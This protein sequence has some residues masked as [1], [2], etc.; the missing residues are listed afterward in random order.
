MKKMVALLLSLLVLCAS[1]A[2]LAEG[3]FYE[4]PIQF[5]EF[6]F[7]DT[8]QNVRN[9]QFIRTIDFKRSA[10]SPRFLAEASNY[11][12][13]WSGERSDSA[14]CF[15]ANLE[16]MREV[17]GHE[18]SVTLWFVYPYANAPE[19]EATLYGGEYEFWEDN[20]QARFE[21]LRQKL[22]KVYG[23]PY[24]Q[25][26][27]LSEVFGALPISDDMITMYNEEAQRYNAEYVVW[28]SSA[29]HTAV[30]LKKYA[31][32]G[33]WE[34]VKL[35]YLWMDAQAQFD[36]LVPASGASAENLSGL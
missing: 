15:S 6:T 28:Q 11:F 31:E 7:G 19:H 22:T 34:R 33:D 4:N 17:A 10:F 36:G 12:A 18:S 26:G 9:T 30:V 3:S 14:V 1:A 23:D 20:A 27:D 32:G 35:A 2:A 21:D 29:N 24:A 25:C 13:E 8:F 5:A 16:E